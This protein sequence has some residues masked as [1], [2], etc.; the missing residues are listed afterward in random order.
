MKNLIFKEVNGFGG[1]VKK[2]KYVWLKVIISALVG[3][4]M[5]WL[6]GSAIIIAF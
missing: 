4:F 1:F 3:A 2:N 5:I 6:I